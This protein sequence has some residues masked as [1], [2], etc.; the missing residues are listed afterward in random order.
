MTEN[1]LSGLQSSVRIILGMILGIFH[2]VHLKKG[3]NS[4]IFC[5]VLSS[6][7][8][9]G[10][11]LKAVLNHLR[12]SVYTVQ[13]TPEHFGFFII[14]CLYLTKK[15]IN[16]GVTFWGCHPTQIKGWSG[17]ALIHHGSLVPTSTTPAAH[18]GPASDTAAWPG[19]S[20]EPC[21]RISLTDWDEVLGDALL[22]SVSQISL[23]CSRLLLTLLKLLSRSLPSTSYFHVPLLT[24]RA[25][26]TVSGIPLAQE[27]NNKRRDSWVDEN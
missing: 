18:L 3:N 27:L 15:F 23:S 16:F 8:A 25:P 2:I 9:L 12:E 17:D 21:H 1:C 7:A 11:G 6:R 14:P 10:K 19:C 22:T 13:C 5:F 20:C 24:S 26:K 4:L